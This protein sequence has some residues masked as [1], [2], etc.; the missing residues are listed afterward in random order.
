[1][2]DHDDDDDHGNDENTD[3]EQPGLR[4]FG[5]CGRGQKDAQVLYMCM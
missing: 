3:A 4:Q 5:T 1:M 2:K